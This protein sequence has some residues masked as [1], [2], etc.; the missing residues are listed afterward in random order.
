MRYLAPDVL[1][2]NRGFTKYLGIEM[3]KELS[4]EEEDMDRKP[5]Q[6]HL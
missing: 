5:D 6:Q 2:W 3:L 1:E 4:Q